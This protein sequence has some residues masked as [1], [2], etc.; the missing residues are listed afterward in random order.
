MSHGTI[1]IGNGISG[2][3]T[4]RDLRKHSNQRIQVI[5]A[6]TPYFFSRTA[7]M[8]VYMGHMKFEQIKPYEDW[9][10][11]KNRIE[12]VHARV[13]SI[14]TDQKRLVLNT[15]E[16]LKYDNLVIAT[17]S[18]PRF[19]GWKGQ[20]LEGVQGLFS[21]QDLQ[22]LEEN[23]PKPFQKDHPTKKAVIT[24]GGLIGVELAE[25][26][27]TRN[28][29]VSILVRESHFWGSV[30]TANEGKW[31][32][33]HIRD[34]G[35]D[36]RLN[37]EM[38]EIAGDKNGRVEAVITAD[39]Q[40]IDCQ[41]VGITT[42]VEPNIEFLKE[43]G[44][45]INR[46]ILVDEWLQTNADGVYAAGDCAEL[47]NPQ[48]GRRALEPVWYVGRMMGEVLGLTLSG[49]KTA[50]KPGPWFNSAK[51]FDIEYMT[52]GKVNPKPAEEEEH[53][54]WKIDGVNKF[55]TLA[56]SKE[57]EKFLGINAFGIRLRHEFF[58]HVLRN[59]WKIGRVVGHLKRANFDPEFSNK[60]FKK[61][62][63]DFKDQT[64]IKVEAPGLFKKKFA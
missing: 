14:E 45:E 48:P 15:G 57:S 2:I 36:L 10:W 30:I 19:F 54:F 25:M 60:W 4:A 32:G 31:I 43:S 38:K 41:L 42:G 62:S 34:H 12:L 8:Y 64:G 6:E 5:S 26:L 16:T 49:R 24:G 27:N 7:L 3:T 9:F 50:Y 59:Q 28:I 47:R 20:D 52:Y 11:E 13:E 56:Y 1:I 39:D 53:F 33:A 58:D 61:L 63:G 17:G 23:T 46:G 55:M 51:F 22:L 29:H 37:T 18:K 21:F 35:I 40:R 44:L